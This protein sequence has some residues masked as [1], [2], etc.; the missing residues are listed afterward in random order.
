MKN[1]CYYLMEIRE[2]HYARNRNYLIR[3]YHH[4]NDHEP[5]I[6]NMFKHILSDIR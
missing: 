4:R 5:D 1:K 3:N 2:Y 6:D